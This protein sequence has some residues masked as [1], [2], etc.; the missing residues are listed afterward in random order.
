MSWVILIAVALV[1]AG[2]AAPR[3]WRYGAIRPAAMQVRGAANII[4]DWKHSETK[5]TQLLAQLRQE[6]GHLRVTVFGSSVSGG[7][8]LHWRKESQFSVHNHSDLDLMVEVDGPTFVRWAKEVYGDEAVTVDKTQRACSIGCCVYVGGEMIAHLPPY[9]KF[10]P[11]REG[12]RVAA[13]RVLGV[14]LA[15]IDADLDIFLFPEEFVR[16]GTGVPAWNDPKRS[17][18]SEVLA[19]TPLNRLRPGRVKLEKFFPPSQVIG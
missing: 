5:N 10:S 8:F 15:Q 2:W 12:R 19:G 6:L 4:S 13:E 14:D 11:T 18:R 3:K 16:T 17:F 9:T 7:K 1:A